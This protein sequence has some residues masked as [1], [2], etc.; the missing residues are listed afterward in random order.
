MMGYAIKAGDISGAQNNFCSRKMI[1]KATIIIPV[2]KP[3][4]RVINAIIP[5]MI[6]AV[7]SWGKI[8][9]PART[10]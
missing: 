5:P 6:N 10:P 4:L 2:L 3:D 7:I 1:T 9:T 8:D